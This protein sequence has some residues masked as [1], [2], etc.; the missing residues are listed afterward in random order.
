[1]KVLMLNGSPRVNGNT[2]AALEEMCS[3][4]AEE[5]VE[6]ELV[7]TAEYSTYWNYGHRIV[8]KKGGPTKGFVKGTF[9]LEKTRGYIEKQLV[10]EFEKEVKAVQSKHD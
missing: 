8:T 2:A 6:T 7:N 10:K 3:V 5:G 4:F 1:M 9:V